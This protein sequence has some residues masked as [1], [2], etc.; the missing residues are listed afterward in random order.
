[1]PLPNY[2]F[3]KGDLVQYTRL[4]L[5]RSRPSNHP[6]T[7]QSKGIFV[8]HEGWMYVEPKHKKALVKWYSDVSPTGFVEQLVRLD[9]LE[10]LGTPR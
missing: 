3:K 10:P 2:A 8:R 5:S 7:E 9:Y 6:K 1:M 4:G